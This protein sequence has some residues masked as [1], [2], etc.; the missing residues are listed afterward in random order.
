MAFKNDI[1]DP[2][3]PISSSN[4]EQTFTNIKYKNIISMINYFSPYKTICRIFSLPFTFNHLKYIG[5]N[6]PNIIFNS[7]TH[8]KLW[9]MNAFKHEIFHRLSG[10]F[11]FLKHL[12]ISNIN[13]PRSEMNDTHCCS[14]IQYPYLISLDFD[15]VDSYYIEQ[16]LNETKTYLP[17]ITELKIDYD[18]LTRVTKNFTNNETRR[19]CSNIKR[20][21]VDIAI[22]Y[23]E[24]VYDYFPLLSI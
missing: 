3:I 23:S 13:P 10:S 9:D 20:L 15:Y 24:D 11:P 14:L 18:D 22:V 2:S 6:L 16:F 19:N 1:L 4:I 5:N 7:V 21:F 17:N 8:L 12:S